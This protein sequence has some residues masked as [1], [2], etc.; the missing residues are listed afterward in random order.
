MYGKR[1]LGFTLVELLVVISIIGLLAALVIPGISGAR[2]SADKAKCVGNLKQFGDR[3]PVH[4]YGQQRKKFPIGI[5]IIIPLG[6][7]MR[8]DSLWEVRPMFP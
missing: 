8:Y 3:Y 4:G 6:T 1:D 2:A 5:I 7:G